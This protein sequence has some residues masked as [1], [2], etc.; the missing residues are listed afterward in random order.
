[1]GPA[2][3]PCTS[4]WKAPRG[5]GLSTRSEGSPQA[6]TPRASRDWGCSRGD[7]RAPLASPG[8]SLGSP[9]SEVP[10]SP[11]APPHGTEGLGLP[12]PTALPRSARGSGGS[13][14]A[15]RRSAAGSPGLSPVCLLA[16]AGLPP[17]V[18]RH[19]G[20]LAH[21]AGADLLVSEGRAARPRGRP[22]T[23]SCCA[24]PG[25]D[26]SFPAVSRQPGIGLDAVNDA[27]LLEASVYRLLKRCCGREPYYLNLLELFLQVRR[28]PGCA[29]LARP[30][31]FRGPGG[32]RVRLD[33]SGAGQRRL[34]L[35]CGLGA[36]PFRVSRS[37]ESPARALSVFLRV[38]IRRRS[39]RAWTSSQPPRATWT[40]ADSL[41]RGEGRGT[42]W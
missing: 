4:P 28:G 11:V 16:A 23:G 42:G 3:F 24:R 29:R 26:G 17:G 6:A 21:P 30:P 31:G 9:S 41:R 5:G 37:G 32:R 8:W 10:G 39:A 38:P 12:G 33:G 34:G 40:W 35:W 13:P 18:G 22:S 7:E 19:H 15:G 20:F 14:G 27:L 36:L 2:S 25:A 1:M